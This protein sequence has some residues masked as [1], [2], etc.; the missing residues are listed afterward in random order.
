MLLGA[1]AAYAIY[2]RTI[3]DKQDITVTTKLADFEMAVVIQGLEDYIVVERDDVLLICKK[4]DEQNIR[5]YVND[6][7]INKGDKYV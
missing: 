2:K 3:G 4:D 7:K 5:Q 6:V 1:I